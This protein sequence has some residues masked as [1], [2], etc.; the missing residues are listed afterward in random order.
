MATNILTQADLTHT[1]FSCR[2]VSPWLD[3]IIKI[4]MQIFFVVTFLSL[5][6]FLY[7]T[8]VEQEIFQDQ[9]NLI[10]DSIYGDIIS[11]IGIVVPP[12]GQKIIK[13]GFYDYINTIKIEPQ[14][15]DDITNQNKSVLD[16]TKQLVLVLGLTLFFIV[17]ALIALRFCTDLSHHFLEN[18]IVLT[19]IALTEFL[20]LNL[21]SRDYISS[22]PKK[23]ELYFFQAVQQYAQQKLA[24]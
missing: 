18:I 14:Q 21:V 17:I 4:F 23:I 3:E 2:F 13:Q 1:N 6:F 16:Q 10:V 20:F 11:T 8:K 5:F 15:Y 22:N 24:Q 19:A 7:V 9:I 12:E